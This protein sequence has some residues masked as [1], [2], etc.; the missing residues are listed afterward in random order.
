[1]DEDPVEVLAKGG[2]EVEAAGR[3]QSASAIAHIWDTFFRSPTSGEWVGEMYPPQ[4]LC[5][6]YRCDVRTSGTQGHHYDFGFSTQVPS[7]H[8]RASQLGIRQSEHTCRGHI[9][10][11]CLKWIT[12]DLQIFT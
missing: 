10:N 8:S 11:L 9:D 2:D 12:S 6:M 7:G 4:A 5:G 1:V 3:L